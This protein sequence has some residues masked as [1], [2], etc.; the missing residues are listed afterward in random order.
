MIGTREQRFRTLPVRGPGLAIT[1][2]PTPSVR[3]L[4][5]SQRE[6]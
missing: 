5:I 3:Q 2:S 6:T 4:M 1:H